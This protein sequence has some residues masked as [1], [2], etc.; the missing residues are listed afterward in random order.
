MYAMGYDMVCHT[1]HLPGKDS[2][3]LTALKH[4]FGCFMPINVRHDV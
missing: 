1:T 3:N 2:K 4:P